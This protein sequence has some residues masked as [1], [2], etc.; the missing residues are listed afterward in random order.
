MCVSVYGR[1]CMSVGT[2]NIC[3]CLQ[4]PAMCVYVSVCRSPQ[5][6]YMCVSAHTMCVHVCRH[7]QCV[8]VCVSIDTHNVCVCVDTHSDQRRRPHP[9]WLDTCELRKATSALNHRAI[10]SVPRKHSLKSCTVATFTLSWV[11]LS[12]APVKPETSDSTR[13]IVQYICLA[14][15][16]L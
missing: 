2:H 8:Y 6:V 1:V 7:A 13:Y 16:A 4:T 10:S 11:G 5:C 12:K 14:P 15:H 9:L 3:V